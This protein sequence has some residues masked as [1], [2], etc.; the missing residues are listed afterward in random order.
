MKTAPSEENVIES[1]TGGVIIS[2]VVPEYDG[3]VYELFLG[4]ASP[5]D[6]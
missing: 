2:S 4:E 5:L 6:R 3:L 1:K